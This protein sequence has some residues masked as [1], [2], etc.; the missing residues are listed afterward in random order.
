MPNRTKTQDGNWLASRISLASTGSAFNYSTLMFFLLTWWLQHEYTDILII[1]CCPTALQSVPLRL[2]PGG[3]S[4]PIALAL[5]WTCYV[6]L[7]EVY[8]S[9]YQ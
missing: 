8:H 5:P 4:G 3:A 9:V 6:G 2:W 7:N 1:R